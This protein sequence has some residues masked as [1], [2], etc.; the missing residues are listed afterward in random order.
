MIDWS[1]TVLAC[2]QAFPKFVD[3]LGRFAKFVGERNLNAWLDEL[4]GGINALEKADTAEAKLAAC[5]Q[6]VDSIRKLHP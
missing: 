1:I 4:E 6:L 5:K 3:L 2:I